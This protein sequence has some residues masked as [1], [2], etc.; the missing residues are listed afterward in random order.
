MTPVT[1]K[2]VAEVLRGLRE[3][4]IDGERYWVT[5]FKVVEKKKWYTQDLIASGKIRLVG[6]NVGVE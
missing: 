5:S 3:F 1:W 2:H 6:A 4:L